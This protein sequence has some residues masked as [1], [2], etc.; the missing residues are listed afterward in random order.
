M[1]AKDFAAAL[2]TLTNGDPTKLATKS[3]VSPWPT[4]ANARY[5]TPMALAAAMTALMTTNDDPP[6]NAT[7]THCMRACGQSSSKAVS[8][9]KGVHAPTAI[10]RTF[11]LD[12]S[13]TFSGPAGRSMMTW[14]FR[15]SSLRAA[16]DHAHASLNS[17]HAVA[18]LLSQYMPV[19]SATATNPRSL[20]KSTLGLNSGMLA[21]TARSKTMYLERGKFVGAWKPRTRICRVISKLD[22][23]T[24]M[25]QPSHGKLVLG[26]ISRCW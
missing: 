14:S 17:T 1:S 22:A 2:R 11:A 18:T 16:L 3:D 12:R 24:K 23:T 7:K 6:L 4:R 21:S 15:N 20:N 19:S 5:T 9:F 26:E 25:T 13:F 8:C 10:L